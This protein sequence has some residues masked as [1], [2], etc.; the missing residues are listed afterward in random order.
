MW[1]NDHAVPAREHL[2]KA[3]GHWRPAWALLRRP[4]PPRV[5]SS[6][7]LFPGSLCKRLISYLLTHSYIFIYMYICICFV[8]LYR[9]SRRCRSKNL[10]LANCIHTYLHINIAFL[11]KQASPYLCVGPRRSTALTKHS[12]LA[13]CIG[14]ALDHAQASLYRL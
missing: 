1:H 3:F 7:G 10:A 13:L 9:W 4:L 8:F 14:T 11:P 12:A 5:P 2:A 6:G